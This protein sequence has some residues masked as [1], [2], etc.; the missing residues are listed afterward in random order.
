VFGT[1]YVA[2]RERE[3]QQAASGKQTTST[4]RGVSEQMLRQI[5]HVV[6]RHT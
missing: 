6:G 1:K 5:K 2:M 4:R 3:N